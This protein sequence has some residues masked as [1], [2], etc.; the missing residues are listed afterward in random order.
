MPLL[1]RSRPQTKGA[2]EDWADAE[3]GPAAESGNRLGIVDWE[4]SLGKTGRTAV[5]TLALKATATARSAALLYWELAL[6]A[7]S[8]L[9]PR[10]ATR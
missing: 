8:L 5:R 3:S 4:S 9:Q 6:S 1:C 2:G 10:R 7:L